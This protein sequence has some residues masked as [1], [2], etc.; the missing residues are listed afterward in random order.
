MKKQIK[1]AAVLGSGVMGS[2]IAAHLVGCG[3]DVL[4]LDIVPFDNMLSDAEKAKKDSDP[5]IRNKM[6]N[7]SL[8]A[9]LKVKKPTPVFYSP[10]DA[11]RITIGNFDDDMPKIADCDWIIEVVV[12]RMDIKKKILGEMAKYRTP[13]TICTSNTSGLSIEGMVEELDDDL[14]ENWLGTHFF[15]P[16][17]HM[18]LLEIIP[19]SKTSKEVLDFMAEFC[20]TV[21]GK[22]VIWAKDTPNFIANRIGVHGIMNGMK[23]MQ[24]MDY[25]IDEVDAIAGQPM[26]RPKTAAYATADLVGLDTLHHVAMTVYNSCTEDPVRDVFKPPK[27]FDEMVERKWLGNKTR[28]GFY[29]RGPEG[30]MVVDWKTMEYVKAEKFKWESTG[31]ARSAKNLG[32]KLQAMCYGDDRAA[33]FAWKLTAD[34]LNYTAGLIPEIS[35]TILE[36]DRGMMWGF[37]FK[38]GPFES[39]DLIGVRKSVEKMEAD[40]MAVP[41]NVKQML[42][43]GNE[44][45]YKEEGGVR[46]QYDLVN[47][48]YVPIQSDDRIFTIAKFEA[49]KKVAGND[50][51]TLW[52]IGD[53]VAMLEFH[54]KMNAIDNEIIE[55][56][57]TSMDIVAD[58]FTGMVVANQAANFSVG[59]NIVMILAAAN[60][61][62]WDDIEKLVKALQDANMRMKYFDKPIVTAPAGMALGGGCEI[63]LHGQKVQAAA[64]TYIG[65]V[66]V[67][68]GVIPAGGGTKEFVL[69]LSE[70]IRGGAEPP[71]L[72]FSMKAFEAIATAKVALGAKDAM[73]MGILRETDQI[74][75]N[76]DYQIYDAKNLVLG[77]AKSGFNPGKPRT[78][79]KVAG[80]GATAAYMVAVDGMYRSGWATDYDRVVAAKVAHVVGGGAM[81]EGTQ[82]SEQYLLDLEREAFLSLLGEQRTKD[83]II[84]MVTTGKPLRN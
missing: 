35:D 24:E 30:K 45:F 19:H 9:A 44:S 73:D 41:E 29:K 80:E 25:R 13:G 79:V 76:R 22:G 58:K 46:Y 10:K 59:A 27:F 55:M 2:A 11:K 68:V 31:N 40:G 53:G 21:L 15:N 20:T 38:V 47:G 49:D 6:G 65:L 3:I 70:G 48:K 67:G 52:D 54:T 56:M 62:M 12:E 18:K 66:E 37:N 32:D 33:E 81:A 51:A 72:P 82:V 64:E 4:M 43:A 74:T 34:S 5:K 16:V 75:I 14:K 1:K 36:V 78:D 84:T 61:E 60:N 28:G 77:M 50:G 8:K 42:A 63:T 7:D 17:R 83:R 23:L 39:W 71:M 57:N 26:G 69:R